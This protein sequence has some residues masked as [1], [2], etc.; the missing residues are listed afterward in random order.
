ML[1]SLSPYGLFLGLFLA[2]FASLWGQKSFPTLNELE[3]QP[4]AEAFLKTAIA[5]FDGQRY[6]QAVLALDQAMQ[7]N[8]E[9]QLSDILF[10]YKAL[11]YLELEEY[12]A[13]KNQLDTAISFVDNKAHYYYY[14]ASALLQLGQNQA[15]Y[16]DLDQ[17]LRLQTDNPKAWLKKGLLLQQQQAYRQALMAYEQAL[18]YQP[19]W[20]EALYYKGVLL[21]QLGLAEKGCQC[22]EEAKNLGLDKAARAQA[23]YCNIKSK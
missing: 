10:Y 13:A 17:S 9:G 22:L 11:C 23:Q 4:K 8:E 7:A 18:S 2:S 1:S 20:T 14:R 12:G 21:L 19:N 3:L 6:R 16:S 15:A 5:Q